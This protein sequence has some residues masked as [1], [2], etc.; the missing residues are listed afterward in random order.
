MP[1]FATD[2]TFVSVKLFIVVTPVERTI[3]KGV[4]NKEPASVKVLKKKS[5]PTFEPDSVPETS[6]FILALLSERY[7]ILFAIETFASKFAIN[8]EAAPSI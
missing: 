3:V 1:P 2:K 8:A 7:E 5:A 6:K 4:S